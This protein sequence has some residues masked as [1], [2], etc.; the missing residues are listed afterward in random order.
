MLISRGRR[1][2]WNILL[3]RSRVIRLPLLVWRFFWCH[4][5][6]VTCLPFLHIVVFL[7]MF[8]WCV[9]RVG[10]VVFWYF[11]LE[12]FAG[13][14]TIVWH[15]YVD[16]ALRIVPVDGYANVLFAFPFVWR[17]IMLIDCCE[18]M[19]GMFLSGVLYYKVIYAEGK[20]NWSPL[21]GPKYWCYFALVVSFR[22]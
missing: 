5:V 15:V 8:V 7:H 20:W 19:F 1:A 17:V 11:M 10:P 3:L 2:L 12:L 4:L 6:V 14:F 22:A 13:F 9:D 21:V 18:E 16:H